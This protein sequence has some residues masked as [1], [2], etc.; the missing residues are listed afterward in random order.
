MLETP[1][2]FRR[3]VGRVDLGT[4]V[5]FRSRGQV[6]RDFCLAVVLVIAFVASTIWLAW[7]SLRLV[8]GTLLLFAAYC[9]VAWLLRVR[10]NHD[11]VGA[12]DGLIDHPLRGSDG[13]NRVL[14]QLAVTLALGRFIA[15]GL[16]DGVRLLTRGELP[17]ERLMQELES[18]PRNDA[19]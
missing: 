19:P 3:R 6:I 8:G 1:E 14:I 12:V 13:A 17:H 18:G 16:V 5:D 15:V 4:T 11:E 7:P 9:A 10:P 2:E